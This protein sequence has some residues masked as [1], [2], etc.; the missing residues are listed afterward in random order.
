ML[1]KW[2]DFTRTFSALDDFRRRINNA[3]EEAGHPRWVYQT[4]QRPAGSWPA[5]NLYD[6]GSNLIV[7]A[8]V[9]GLTEDK[10]QLSLDENVLSISGERKVEVP[11]DYAVHRQERSSIKFARSFSLPSKVDSEKVAAAVKDG[12]L[13]VTMEKAK[14]AQPRKITIKAS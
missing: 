13:T 6:E 8:E 12:L 9:P 4:D 10:I 14:E 3:L 7:E 5:I 2:D 11:K 1:T